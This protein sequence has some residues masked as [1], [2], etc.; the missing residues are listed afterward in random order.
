M[1]NHASS[2]KRKG[3]ETQPHVRVQNRQLKKPFFLIAPVG[4]FTGVTQMRREINGVRY[5]LS[6]MN[7]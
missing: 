1:S 6:L 4:S 7:Q 2:G 3:S 5:H